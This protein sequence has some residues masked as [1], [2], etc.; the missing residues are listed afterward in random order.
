MRYILIKADLLNIEI[1]IPSDFKI[2]NKEEFERHL[3][4]FIDANGF[5]KN[6][7]NEIR[8]LLKRERI[9]LRLEGAYTDP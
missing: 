2:L 9:Q 3:Y 7:T 5:S 6:Y 8:T 1:I 4:P